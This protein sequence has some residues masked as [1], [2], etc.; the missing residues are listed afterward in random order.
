MALSDQDDRWYPDKLEIL[1]G[2]IRESGARLAY[3]DGRAVELDGTVIRASMWGDGER[4]NQWSDLA[5]M[6]IANTV[7]GAASLMRRE[8]AEAALPFPQLPGKPYHDH[9]LALVALAG[10]DLAYVDQP[11]YDWVRHETSVVVG[12]TQLLRPADYGRLEFPP[13]LAEWRRDEQHELRRLELDLRRARE[14]AGRA[15]LRRQ[16][17]PYAKDRP[18]RLARRSPLAHRTL[19]AIAAAALRVA[20]TRAASSARGRRPPSRPAARASRRA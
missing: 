7:T 2:A 14:P 19:A 1:L 12:E 16:A 11:L 13:K 3:G 15:D 20:R 8:V 18:G 17:P 10:G 6:L 4:P 9:W 5:T